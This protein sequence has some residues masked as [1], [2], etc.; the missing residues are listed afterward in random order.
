MAEP[1]GAAG[2]V[3]NNEENDP[4]QTLGGGLPNVWIGYGSSGQMSGG[5]NRS[6]TLSRLSSALSELSLAAWKHLSPE[7]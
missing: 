6:K 7:I 4:I 1:Y 5:R 2:H 3:S